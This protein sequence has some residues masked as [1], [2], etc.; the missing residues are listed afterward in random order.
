MESFLGE[1]TIPQLSTEQVE[2]LEAPLTIDEISG[3]LAAL[4][5][6]KSPG[7]DGLP[8]ESY[9]TYSEIMIPRLL[10]LYKAIFKD[11]NLP[12]SMREANISIK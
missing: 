7:S 1:L 12:A 10:Q 8:V 5:G 4:P 2:E 9:S 11:S 6:S 3:A